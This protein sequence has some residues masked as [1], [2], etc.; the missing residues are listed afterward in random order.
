MW[1]TVWVGRWAVEWVVV[2]RVVWEEA[3]VLML[4]RG[5]WAGE[6]DDELVTR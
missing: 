3:V 2:G 5:R 6:A 4:G 1:K